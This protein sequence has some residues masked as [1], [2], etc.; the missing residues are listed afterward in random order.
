MA[1]LIAQGPQPQNRW[2]RSLP[3]GEVMVLGRSS[4]QWECPWDEQL[5]RRHA[6][7]CWQG[8]RLRV[9][10]LPSGRNPIFYH[11][12]ECDTFE[13][14]PGDTFVIGQTRFSVSVDQANVSLAEGPQPAE[15]H[16]LSAEVLQQVRFRNADQ[17]IEVLG[18]LPDVISGANT[19][20]E[21]FVRLVNLLLAGIPRCSAV[22]VVMADPHETDLA[23]AEEHA[24]TVAHWDRR[25]GVGGFE[26]SRRLIVEAVR[27]RESV[28]H[29]WEA[30]KENHAFTASENFDW[31]FCTPVPGE[32][33]A[34]WA[35]YVTGRMGGD[36]RG[37][38]GEG[39][40]DLREEVKFSEIVAATL[41][42]LRQ[43]RK[44]E[45]KHATLSQFLPPAVMKALEVQDAEQVL[46]PRETE[47]SV[48]FCDLRGF[49]RQ[50]EQGYR[51]PGSLMEVL[52]RVSKALGVMTH[53]ILDQGGVVGDFQ[54]DAAMG[55]WGWP[56]PQDDLVL[57][58]CLAALAIR[59]EFE[60]AALRP[61]HTLSDFQV[62]IGLATG[63]AVAGGIGTIDQLKV[64]VFG[65]V[66][67]LASRLEGMTKTLRAPILMD[68]AT[69][70]VVREQVPP[71]L[72]R[73]RRVAKVR[74]YGMDTELMV[75]ELLPPENE[76]P[77]LTAAHLQAYEQ[78][79]DDFLAGRWT[80][81]LE[82]LQNVPARD[83]V[84]DFITVY[85][86]QRG[87]IPPE[88]WDG[89]IALLSK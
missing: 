78:A 58:A 88:D 27:R 72:A 34:G 47:V 36:W 52:K 75:S 48:L 33:C 63:E 10:R 25:A 71:H 30:N 73:C 50:V 2:R 41:S 70:R 69:A 26:P 12:R 11:G 53:H 29:V 56:L 44:L 4:A 65:P 86:A 15:E 38:L 35:L 13:M 59:L 31:A 20:E 51:G 8:G 39:A 74:P 60:A 76:Y 67:N 49:S 18:H 40:A 57:R 32:A 22:A 1:D 37:R 81:A 82:Q 24:L 79:L 16:T 85:I 5:S 83:R 14:S 9:N 77:L 66:V 28:L 87:R 55:F 23:H 42:S 89:V 46:A 19:D 68:E 6:E 3:L 45:R 21:L 80:E 84:K 54:G 43:V 62:G 64:S 17:R 7:I 61:G